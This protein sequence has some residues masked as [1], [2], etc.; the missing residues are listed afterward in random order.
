MAIGVVQS[1]TND[2][3]NSTTRTSLGVTLGSNVTAGNLVVI[4]AT[5]QGSGGTRTITSVSDGNSYSDV[6]T[7]GQDGSGTQ[8]Q[9][10]YYYPNHA[11]GSTTVTV[12]WSGNVNYCSVTAVELS[13]AHASTPFDQVVYNAQEPPGTG[14]DNITSTALTPSTD[15]CILLGFS[16]DT[17]NLSTGTFV[18][19][20]DFTESIASTT[21]GGFLYMLEYYVQTTAASKAATFTQNVNDD[22][23]TGLCIFKPAAVSGG[24]F[25]PLAGAGGLAGP[26]RGLAG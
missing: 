16:Q 18:A 22:R 1:A 9:R 10:W 2:Q 13:G 23:L 11:G 12:T 5:W 19:G 24:L 25:T 4:I 26:I 8:R 15:N 21:F 6:G 17:I 14:T 3:Y 7:E 20:T